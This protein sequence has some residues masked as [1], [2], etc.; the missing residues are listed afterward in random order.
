MF[1]IPPTPPSNSNE[2]IGKV[3]CS[4]STSKWTAEKDDNSNEFIRKVICSPSTSNWTAE[5]NDNS[6]FV[7]NANYN[8][9]NSMT[10]KRV[11]QFPEKSN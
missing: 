10:V 2:I 9:C 5:K 4:P 8:N 3:L 7:E 1:E 11:L 6:K